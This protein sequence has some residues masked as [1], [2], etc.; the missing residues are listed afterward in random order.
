MKATSSLPLDERVG[1]LR[2]IL[3]GDGDLHVG[4]F[5]AKNAH[6]FGQPVHFLS[7][8]EA[9]GKGWLGWFCGAARRFTG[10][11]DLR[12]RQ[13]GMVEEDAASGS[14]F[15]AARAADHKLSADLVFEIA[16]LA[17]EGR[18]RR[19]QSPFSAATVRLPSSATATK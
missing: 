1:K 2:R 8:Q 9:K 19:V 15:D 17:A 10:R 16:D 4:K 13:P 18:L 6:G 11:L 7:G 5:I 12:Q 14:Q 3:A